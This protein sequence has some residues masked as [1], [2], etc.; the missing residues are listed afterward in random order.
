MDPSESKQRE[1]YASIQQ[2]DE[3]IQKRKPIRCLKLF[4]FVSFI[5]FLISFLLFKNT[6]LDSIIIAFV[7]SGLYLFFSM[8][9]FLPF[10]RANDIENKQLEDMKAEYKKEFG[11][12]F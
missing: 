11:D 5:F 9:V 6:I 4:L 12:T 3:A 8:I 10:I 1:M 2:L 7:F